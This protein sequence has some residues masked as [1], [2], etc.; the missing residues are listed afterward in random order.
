MRARTGLW[1]PRGGNALGPPGPVPHCA[2]RSFTSAIW[3]WVGLWNQQH[4][5]FAGKR[6]QSFSCGVNRSFGEATFFGLAGND[7]GK[8]RIHA[9]RGN[10]R[11]ILL[12]RP[13]LDGSDFRR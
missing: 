12:K 1:E 13:M 5:D 10:S 3:D 2:A 6:W 11:R 7:H 4:G 9:A 8:S